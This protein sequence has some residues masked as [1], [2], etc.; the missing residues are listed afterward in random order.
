M[1]G[2]VSTGWAGDYSFVMR[3]LL[4]K[5]FRIRYRNMS[6]GLGW[7]LLNPLV[8]MGVFTFVFTKVY[9]HNAKEAYPLFLLCGLI[10]L[11]FFQLAWSSATTSLV[12]NAGLIKR[13]R[14]PRE[15]VPVTTV[16]GNCMHFLIQ[17]AL[18]LSMALI[19]KGINIHWLWLPVVIALE[20]MF[21]VGA[22][23]AFS[24]INVYIRDTKYV[25]ESVNLVLIWLVPVFYGFEDIPQ[26]YVEVYRFNPIAAVV[27]LFRKI[28]MENSAPDDRTMLNLAGVAVASLLTGYMIF[29]RLKKRFYDY[30]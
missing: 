28:L 12:D 6:L 15:V 5:D 29:D 19:W 18:L 7:S 30:L 4:L 16:L 17:L 24:A 20:V 25:V 3:T 8:M 14:F 2:S 9:T 23:L 13:T 10:P 21:V 11:G 22:G 26:K 27:L 1:N